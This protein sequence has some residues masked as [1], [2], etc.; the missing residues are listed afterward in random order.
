MS[1]LAWC[2]A[3]TFRAVVF[4][5]LLLLTAQADAG[6]EEQ[7]PAADASLQSVVEILKNLDTHLRFLTTGA[8]WCE[9]SEHGQYRLVVFS[10]GFEE[11]Y[12]HLYVQ[13]LIVDDEHHDIMVKRTIPITETGGFALFFEGLFMKPS[14]RGICNDAVIE[15][16]AVR[17]L[18]DGERRERVHLRVAPTGQYTI[19]FEPENKRA[20]E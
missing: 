10:G 7:R 15:G 13:L 1:M 12:D 3:R 19:S 5:T 2:L 18:P 16:H 9:G 17:R 6:A 20:K 11:V 8:T 14:G 4:L